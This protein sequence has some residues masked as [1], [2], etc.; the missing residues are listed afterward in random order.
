MTGTTWAAVS[1]KFRDIAVNDPFLAA[2]LAAALIAMAGTPIAFAVLGRLSWFTARR[3]RVLQRPEFSSIVCAMLLVMGIPAIF[4]ALLIKSQSFDKDRYEFDPNKSW[5]VLEQG[6]GYADVK[7]ADQAVKVEMA[8]LA[9]ERKNLVDSVKK[10]DEAMLKLRAVAG[11]SASVAKA[12]PPV[13]QRLAAIRRSVGV[14]GP[15]QLMDFTAPP[16]EIAANL[17]MPAPN[18]PAPVATAI[19]TP[20]ANVPPAAP[21]GAGLPKAQADAELAT[22]PAPQKA[23]AAMLPLVNIPAGWEVGSLGESHIETFNADNLFEKIDGRAESFVDYKVKG[24]AYANYHPVGDDS[25]EVQVYIFELSDG[26]KAFGKYGTEKPEEAKLIAVGT[27]GYTASGSTLFYQGP[28]YTQIVSTKDDPVYATFALDLA[29][30]IAAAQKPA[31]AAPAESTANGEKQAAPAPVAMV[32]PETLFTLL[33]A[34]P[35]RGAPKYVAQDVFGYSFLSDVFMADYEDKGVTWQGFLRPYADA[36]E[37][38]ASLEKYKASA[39]LDGAKVKSE[40]VEGADTFLI[41]SNIGLVDAFFLKGNV[42]AGVNGSTDAAVAES[43]ARAFAKGLPAQVPM[44][45][46]PAK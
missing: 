8:R 17:A 31:G 44:I 37:A 25:G 34:G 35:G 36:A 15:Q 38:K 27:E 43:F 3:G 39:A 29:K 5:S 7:Q 41:S 11:T 18:G 30:R 33:P 21:A 14:D 9:E 22:V 1:S 6:R 10:L 19:A 16:V 4:S 42:I 46:S 2:G 20:A 40:E 26:L 28:Y 24:M 45:G 32:T 13:L 12:V 23:I